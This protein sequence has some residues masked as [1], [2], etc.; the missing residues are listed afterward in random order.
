MSTASQSAAPDPDPWVLDAHTDV[1]IRLHEEPA[2]L[3]RQVEGRHVDLPKLRR[4]GVGAVFFALFVPPHLGVDEGW[5]LVERLYRL[6]LDQLRHRGWRAVRSAEE[7]ERARACGEVAVFFGLENGR[8]LL[9]PGALDRCAEIGVRY[10]TLTHGASHEWCDAATDRPRHGGLS[11]AGVELVRRMNDHRILVD[12]SH[13]SEQAAL[14]AIEVSRLP[15]IAS[16]SSAAALC[17]HPG[18]LSD[19][20]IRAVAASGGVVMANSHPAM[21]DPRACLYSQERWR[22]IAPE[23]ARLEAVQQRDPQAYALGLEELFAR[24]PLPAVGLES[25]VRHLLH[26]VEVAGGDHVGIGSDFDGIPETLSGFEDASCFPALARSLRASDLA[27]SVVAGIMG[28]NFL[29]LL[30]TVDQISD[31][32][33]NCDL[34]RKI[35]HLIAI[36]E[37]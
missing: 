1:P 4:G 30:R 22:T 3:R 26:L 16:H 18:N 32:E 2:D 20:L 11:S 29:R 24:H 37:I 23:L 25:Y 28:K 8:C 21:L 13:V 15:V 36:D 9:H 31:P 10:V 35:N 19:T 27:A 14:Q 6:S 34:F 12:V 7:A 5:R 17:P 33:E